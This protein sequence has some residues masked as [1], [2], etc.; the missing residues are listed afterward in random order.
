[1]IY[2][3]LP[4]RDYPMTISQLRE[5]HLVTGLGNQSRHWDREWRAQL[6]HNLEVM[7]VQLWEVGI[8]EIFVDGS[9]VENKDH[10]HDIDG[11]FV[12]DIR[13]YHKFM[14]GDP[15]PLGGGGMASCLPEAPPVL[16]RS[17]RFR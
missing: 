4:P 5:S 13:E 2:D 1:M 10:P 8:K 14:P 11:Y 6:V 9:F 16:S 17:N 12:C 7:V 15:L 3:L